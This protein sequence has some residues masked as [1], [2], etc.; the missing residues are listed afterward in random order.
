[1]NSKVNLRKN[2]DFF[3][4]EIIVYLRTFIGNY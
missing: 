2:K 3:T 4:K 1:M